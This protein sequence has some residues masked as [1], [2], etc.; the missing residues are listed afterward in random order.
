MSRFLGCILVTLCLAGFSA[1]TANAEGEKISSDED[2][3][4]I[5]DDEPVQ[6]EEKLFHDLTEELQNGEDS[7]M[8]I[9]VRNKYR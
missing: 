2:L 4:I 3:G 9:V 5:K 8:F 1:Q 6:D 7:S